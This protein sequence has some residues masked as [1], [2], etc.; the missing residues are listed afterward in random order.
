MIYYLF[1]INFLSFII[2]GIDKYRSIKNKY[3]I[4]EKN[5]YLLSF[6]G[7]SLGSIVGMKVFHHKTKK[8]YFWIINILFLII[9]IYI[10]YKLLLA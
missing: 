7:G 3:R 2:Y 6:L 9:W 4:S 10:I 5:L 8:I 1:I